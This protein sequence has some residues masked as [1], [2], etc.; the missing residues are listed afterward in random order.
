M[1]YPNR[2]AGGSEV[3]AT[4]L[5]WQ[6]LQEMPP[7]SRRVNAGAPPRAG[8]SFL[9]TAANVACFLSIASAR[10]LSHVTHTRKPAGL[11]G[12]SHTG[13]KHSPGLS[14]SETNSS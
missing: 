11:P 5:F 1:F 10:A 13:C 12:L 7:Q 9:H 14:A 6:L 8:L 4:G 3:L 2:S